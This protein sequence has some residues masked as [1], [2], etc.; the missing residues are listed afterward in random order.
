MSD[1]SHFHLDLHGD[2]IPG[3]CAGLAIKRQD[4]GKPLPVEKYPFLTTLYSSGISGL[5]EKARQDYGFEPGGA[6]MT[7]CHLC[8]EIR[9]FLSNL[10]GLDCGELKPRDFY[11]NL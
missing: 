8:L 10:P 2:Y 6:Y 3:L 7:K 4:L 1:I 5:L 9:K 11:D